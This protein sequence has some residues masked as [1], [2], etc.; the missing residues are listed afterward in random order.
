[1]A[2]REIRVDPGH[3]ALHVAVQEQHAALPVELHHGQHVLSHEGA[4]RGGVVRK[5]AGRV[6]EL[7]ALHDELRLG[8]ARGAARVV[9]V[10]VRERHVVDGVG[11][12]ADLGE[13]SRV[14]GPVADA[15]LLPSS[16][17]T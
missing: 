3:G 15:E 10:H 16:G 6:L 9:P 11:A 4:L 7:A 12:E 5:R 8:E 1:V 13:Q 17:F 14:L 2:G